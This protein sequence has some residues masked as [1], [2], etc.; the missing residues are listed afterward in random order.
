[1]IL[2]NTSTF[3]QELNFY[4]AACSLPNGDIIITGGGASNLVY[5]ISFKDKIKI[6]QR[7]PMSFCRKEHSCVL[8]NGN[9]YVISGYDGKNKMMHYSCEMYDE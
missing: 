8:L 4:S 3:N 1:M 6:F 9:V 5:Q 7:K 2:P